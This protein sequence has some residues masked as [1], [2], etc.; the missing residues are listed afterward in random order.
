MNVLKF[1]QRIWTVGRPV[2]FVLQESIQTKA[3]VTFRDSFFVGLS[4]KFINEVTDL[5]ANLDNTFVAGQSVIGI[6]EGFD[7]LRNLGVNFFSH[8]YSLSL[9]SGSQAYSDFSVSK[10]FRKKMGNSVA[11][12]KNSSLDVQIGGEFRCVALVIFWHM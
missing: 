12:V 7:C 8:R 4:K 10:I 3:Y 9:E 2:H 5:L 11:I 1:W 6:R